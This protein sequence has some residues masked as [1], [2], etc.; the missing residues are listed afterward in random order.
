[1]D[2]SS[3]PILRTACAIV[4]FA[5]ASGCTALKRFS[6]EGLHRD[7]WQHPERVVE[8]LRIA[9]GDRVADL[10]AGGGYF[11]FRLA[12]ATGPDGV[13]Y[14]VDVDPGMIAYLRERAAASGYDNVQVVEATPDD[15]HLP[16][17][18]VD[19]VFTCNTYHHIAEQSAYFARV[20]QALAPGGRVVIVEPRND[21]GFFVPL[22]GWHA[23]EE[24]VIRRD[25]GAAGYRL[26]AEYYFLPGQSFLVYSPD[27]GP[28][29]KGNDDGRPAPT[30][31]GTP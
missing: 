7:E 1:M 3:K 24:A 23:T 2:S 31:T 22:F 18:N 14:A 25:M 29:R 11:T 9:K 5:L 17:G 13:V 6:Y 20:K 26:D 19:L 4:L 8:T 27:R 30:A 28:P 12:D 16:A 21:Q 15:P 10:G